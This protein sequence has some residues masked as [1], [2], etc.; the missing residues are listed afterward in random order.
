[1]KLKSHNLQQISPQAIATFRALIWDH[2]Q[3][4]GR[5]FAWREEI[6]PYRVFVSEV[7]LQ[8]TQT[9]RV[10]PKFEAWM[11]QLPSF[12]QLAQAPQAEVLKLW[13]GLGYNRRALALHKSAQIICRDYSGKLPNDPALLQELPGIGPATA[14]SICAFAFNKPTIFIETNIRAVFLHHF[15]PQQGDVSD[16]QLLPLVG[17]CL[18]HTN[19]RHWYYALMDYG[20]MLKKN[21]P[22]PS[23]KSKHHQVQSKFEGS[24]RQIRGMI[25]K[26]LTEH[27]TATFDELCCAIDRESAR[28]QKNLVALCKEGFVKNN[29]NHYVL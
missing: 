19:A 9:Y 22:N 1:M 2:Y 24:E 10:A 20:V 23:R 28:I 7:M 17:N 18:E 5:K 6:S 13:Q 27:G 26:Y 12:E 14:A 3:K 11:Q 16:K 4:N 21:I 15:F 8:Q 29:V 25:L